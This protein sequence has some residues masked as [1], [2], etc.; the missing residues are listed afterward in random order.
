L[1]IIADSIVLQEVLCL[2]KFKILNLKFFILSLVFLKNSSYKK[3][4][5]LVAFQVLL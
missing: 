5:V 4:C 1:C 2:L 3:S